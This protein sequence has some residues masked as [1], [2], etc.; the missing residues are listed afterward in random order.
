M[1]YILAAILIFGLLI[2][3]HEFGHFAAA[4]LCGVRVNE[5]SVGMGPV[6]F[7]RQ[8]GDTE[9][10]LRLLPVGGFCAMEGETEDSDDPAALNNQ[11]FLK[12]FVIFAAGAAVNFLAGFLILLVLYA[13]ATAFYGTEIVE[14]HEDFPQQGESGLMI[15]D[16]LYAI[17]GERVYLRSDVDIIFKVIERDELGTIELTV[18]RDGEKLTRTLTLQTYVNENGEEYRAYGFSYGGIEEGTVGNRL[19]YSWYNTIDFARLVRLS[20]MMLVRGDAGI[21]DLSGPVGIV[22]SITKV[23]EETQ[24]EAGV[25][26]A[27]ENVFF[28][29]A[30]IAVNLAVMNLLPIPALDGGRIFFLV[31]N[32]LALA[33]FKRK[34]PE[35]YENYIH[36]AGFI[37]LMAL[38]LFVT[39][40]D[41]TKLF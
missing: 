17:N 14:L 41:V 3:V 7:K 11:S 21:D 25:L 33:I 37:L 39:L 9:Y 18:L 34:I 40:N 5:F 16:Q 38:M 15:G 28:F 26:A 13:P 4:K 22:S 23:G 6:I 31:V 29:G 8:K 2:A 1:L 10:S 12:K 19:K 24:K 30:M 20:I 32:T 35:K 36:A 27:L